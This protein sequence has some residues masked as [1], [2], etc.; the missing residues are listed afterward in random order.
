[1]TN[2][3]EHR[4]YLLERELF[5][6]G[7]TRQQLRD[8]TDRIQE[9]EE[10]SRSEIG[11]SL[12]LTD[13]RE[14][15]LAAREAAVAAREEAVKAREEQYARAVNAEPLPPRNPKDAWLT[16]RANGASYV[17]FIAVGWTDELLEQHGLMVVPR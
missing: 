16:E 6:D 10:R 2:A 9:L 5:T 14:S 8:L 7:D 15:R 3:L 1:M 4:V 11:E 17:Q 13:Y 12:V